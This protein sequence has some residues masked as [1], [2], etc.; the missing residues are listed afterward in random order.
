MT[1]RLICTA[2]LLV[3]VFGASPATCAEWELI[4]TPKEQPYLFADFKHDDGGRLIVMCSKEENW[5]SVSFAE[6][7]AQWKKGESINLTTRSDVP[8]AGIS[9]DGTQPTPATG[10]VIGTSQLMIG[11]AHP[12]ADNNWDLL[13][14]V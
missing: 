14:M 9:G 13:I 1:M 12:P 7:R 11:G 10:V 4:P 6:P 8:I 2:L 3:I 5:I